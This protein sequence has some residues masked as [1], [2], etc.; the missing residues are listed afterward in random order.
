MKALK[1]L[2]TKDLIQHVRTVQQLILFIINYLKHASLLHVIV[3]ILKILLLRN[4]IEF[5]LEVLL[6]IKKGYCYCTLLPSKLIS[7]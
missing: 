7:Y 4:H 6:Y 2:S 3:S 1:Y 5:N